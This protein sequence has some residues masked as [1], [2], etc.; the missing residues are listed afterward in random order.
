VNLFIDL[1]VSHSGK[2]MQDQWSSGL[3]LVDGEA[4]K[5]TGKPV[6]GEFINHAAI[7]V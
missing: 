5:H 3:K 6:H 4:Q 7:G 1:I 2:D